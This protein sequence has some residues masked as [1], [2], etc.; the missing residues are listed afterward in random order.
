MKLTLGQASKE[1]GVSKGTLSK[2]LKSGRLSYVSKT[3]AGYEIDPAEL[4]RVFPPK[5]REPVSGERSETPPIP[6]GSAGEE[7]GIEAASI[8]HRREIEMLREQLAE[9]KADR[10]AWREQAQRLALPAPE[11]RSSRRWRWF[12][13]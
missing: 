3:A 10:D 13:R 2:A 11:E 12:G 4:F 1:T 5:Q 6:H 7:R 8:P 9:L